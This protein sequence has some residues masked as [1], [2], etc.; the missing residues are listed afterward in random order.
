MTRDV[1][2]QPTACMVRYTN[3][4]KQR[5]RQNNVVQFVVLAVCL[6]CCYVVVAVACQVQLQITQDTAGAT[7]TFKS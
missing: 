6:A 1:G 2:A 4:S 3:D 5:I 7:R